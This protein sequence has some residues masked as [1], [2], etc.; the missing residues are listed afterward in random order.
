MSMRLMTVET[1]RQARACSSVANRPATIGM[2]ADDSAPGRDELEDEVRD[3]E[4]GEERVELRPI[5]PTLRDD[6]DPDPAEDP[7]RR[8]TRRRR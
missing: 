1:T 8:G 4:G 7:R 3:P 6:D 5:G 2:S